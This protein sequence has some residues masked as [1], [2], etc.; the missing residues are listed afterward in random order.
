[1]GDANPHTAVAAAAATATATAATNENAVDDVHKISRLSSVVPN[2]VIIKASQVA[3]DSPYKSPRLRTYEIEVRNLYYKII[4]RTDRSGC[5]PGARFFQRHHHHHHHHRRH[6]HHQARYI[7]RNVSCVARPGEILAVAGPSGAG[8]STLLEVL[9]GRIHPS[10]GPSSSVSTVS[11]KNSSILVNNQPIDFEH[12]RRVSGYVMQHDALFPL[13]TV[14]ET[15]LF[16]AQL[17]LPSSLPKAEKAARVEA[18]MGE[19][20]LL[21]VAGSRIGNENVRGVSGGERRRVSIGVDVIHDPAVLLLDEPTSGLDSAGALQVIGMLNNMAESHGRTIILSIHQPGFRILQ[22]IHNILLLANGAV[23]HHGSIGLLATRLQEAGHRIPQQVNV[24][25]YAIDTI[26]LFEAE[27]SGIIGSTTLG[28]T[29]SKVGLQGSLQDLFLMSG[30]LNGDHDPAA[31]ASAAAAAAAAAGDGGDVEMA[32]DEVTSEVSDVNSPGPEETHLDYANSRFQEIMVLS[33]RFSKNIIR[34]RQLFAART[35]QAAV[36]GLGLGSI[37][38]RLSHN[39]GGIQERYGFFAFTLTFLLSS[40]TEALPLYLQ[41]KQ[42]LM[43]ETSRGAYRVSSYVISNT[44]VFL[45]F[46]LVCSLLYSAPTYWLVGLNPCISS[47]LFFVLVVWLIVV[48]ANS[49]VAFFSA[50]VPNF[51]MGYSLI[52]GSIG[53]FFLFS[54]YFIAKDSIPEYWIFM[55]Y[56]SLFKYPLDALLINE[57]SSPPNKSSCYGE[58]VA[59]KCTLSGRDVLVQAALEND[60]KW[61]DVGVMIGFAIAYRCLCCLVLGLKTRQKKQ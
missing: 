32:L 58:M 12:F 8:K 57:Y 50:L 46:L 21:H 39:K 23:I 10:H 44:L 6:H 4:K 31:A 45:P 13:L 27:K 37:F 25:E 49:F 24:L 16:S 19:L 47:Y 43:R 40:T 1:M 55:H 22:L 34:T 61:L 17:R 18:L 48:M 30:Q 54:G 29:R 53:A 20:G 11:P 3:M 51:I 33:N 56:I 41:E 9:A 59:G 2:G 42:I 38:L 5:F 7:L 52:S 15:L 26:D 14:H 28:T 35:L 60:S 36:A